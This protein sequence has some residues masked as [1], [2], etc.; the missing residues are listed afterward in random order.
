M[1][2]KEPFVIYLNISVCLILLF[3][4]L[5]SLLNKKEEKK[6]RVSFSLIFFTVIINCTSNVVILLWENVQMVPIVFN[7]FCIPLLFGPSVYFYVK[8]LLGYKVNNTLYFSLIP[9]IISFAYGVYL[10]LAGD[11]TK[12][13]VLNEIISG[14]HFFFNIL[15]AIALIYI[16]IYCVK[17]WFFL[18]KTRQNIV[19]NPY[20]LNKMKY[21]WAKEFILYIFIPVFVF[22]IIHSLIIGGF[23]EGSLM[24]MDL[25]WMPVFMLIVYL[26]I[27]IRSIMLYK[28]FEHQFV[29]AKIEAEKD[30]QEQRLKISGNLHDSLG[31]Q[32]TFINTILS[33]LK[34]AHSLP[35]ATVNSKINMLADL[36]ENSLREINSTLWVLNAKEIHL[37]ELKEKFLN[38]INKASN[39][40]EDVNFD[41]QFEVLE[42]ININS[43][44]AVNLF[45]TLQEIVNNALKHAHATEIKIHISQNGRDLLLIIIDNGKGFD[46]ENE[47][48]KSFGLR[49]IESRI[50]TINGQFRLETS[51]GKGAKY[52]IQIKL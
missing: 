12:H 2:Y 39:A 38:F 16:L 40:K 23:I 33:G 21:D 25:I 5:P 29:L 1:L 37:Q 46:Y 9:G 42:N 28:D 22:S 18:K 30:L 34:N 27:A 7:L 15:N 47:K 17:A 11:K 35:E 14:T 36:S 26:W 50:A 41:F 31:S 3:L 6:L 20:Q 43:E 44:Q 48:N 13:L 45:R 49:N 24:D 8:T 52:H 51:V 4:A 32:L 19:D 10:V